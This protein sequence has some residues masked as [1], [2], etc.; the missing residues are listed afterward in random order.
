MTGRVLITGARAPVALHW[1]RLF[2]E[3]GWQVRSADSLR[4]PIA[5]FSR[6]IEGYR[7]YPSPV[8]EPR[9]FAA[10]VAAEIADFAPDLVLPTCEEVFHLAALAAQPA[11]QAWRDRLVAPLLPLLLRLH[12]K[13]AFNA[14]VAERVPRFAPR[15]KRL[16]SPEARAA[17][18]PSA[19]DWV[20]KPCFSRF[21]TAVLV[22]P[23]RAALA[24]LDPTA[25]RPWLAQEYLPGAEVC[26]SAL[27]HK[28]AL[29]A[30][31]AYHPLIRLKGGGK[32]SSEQGSR[33]GAGLVFEAAGAE[34]HDILG[35]FV[36]RLIA[37]E[38][39]FS[40][41]LSF[42][43]R[44]DAQGQWKAIECN[45]RSTSG[46]HFFEPGD[47]LVDALGPGDASHDQRVPSPVTSLANPGEIR[48]EPLPAV[49]AGGLK[50]LRLLP[51]LKTLSA[52]PGD[53]LG[54][55]PQARAFA[56]LV[57]MQHRHACSLEEAATVDICWNGPADLP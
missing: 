48:G 50:G 42:D 12:D 26:L 13:G 31:Q 45:P 28:G 55:L 24:A 43:F 15:F 29:V 41:Q 35:D 3:A 38:P 7:R 2:A 18:T 54:L 10:A 20:F 4:H 33:F 5:R 25:D 9:G 46:F 37:G 17:L 39:A 6:L 30:L 44:A 49:L 47:G 36:R 32:G 8:F 27:V 19:R 57:Q 34:V 51:R 23:D 22:R 56:E 16:E 53:R 40:G 14:L 1:C 52:W 11:G 21:A